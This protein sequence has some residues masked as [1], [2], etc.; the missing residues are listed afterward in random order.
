MEYASRGN[1]QNQMQ[2]N[3]AIS[4]LGFEQFHLL[5]SAISEQA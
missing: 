4:L 2:H 5:Q 3:L 1:G